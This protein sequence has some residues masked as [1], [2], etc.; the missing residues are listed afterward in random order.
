MKTTLILACCCAAVS[1]IAQ[2]PIDTVLDVILDNNGDLQAQQALLAAQRGDDTDANSLSN[3]EVEFTRVWGKD[4]IGN[5]LQLDISQSFDWPGLYRARSQAARQGQAAI[6]QS[7]LND[8]LELALQAKALLVELVYVRKQLALTDTLVS[9]LERMKN[10]IAKSLD[11]GEITVLDERKSAYELFKYQNQVA[12]LRTREAE[13]CAELSAMS[14]VPLELNQIQEYPLEELL[15]Q[16]EYLAQV[17]RDP[18]LKSQLMMVEQEG[19]NARAARMSRFP[20]FS[21]GYEH[22]A[23]MGDR[24]NGFTAGMTLPFFENRKAR[25]S[26][27]YRRDASQRSA[28][29]LLAQRVADTNGKLAS[30]SILGDQ[31]KQFRSVFGDNLYLR[32]LD[33]A[34]SAGQLNVLEYISELHYFKEQTFTYLETEYNYYSVLISLNRYNLLKAR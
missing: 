20:S 5:K 21:L 6:E 11:Q 2:S 18:S 26:A 28:Q 10:S 16:E 23:E 12:N 19:M 3:P 17:Q 14:Q 9:N 4:G 34:F 24:F 29:M 7:M 32:Y 22:Q 27:L 31:M 8:R 33:M 13:V 15:S 25:Q 30:L 1:A